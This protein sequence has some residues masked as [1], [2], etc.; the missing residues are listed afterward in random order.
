MTFADV[1]MADLVWLTSAITSI[2]Q[3]CHRVCM[4]KRKL[5]VWLP[6]SGTLFKAKNFRGVD[7]RSTCVS[8]GQSSLPWARHK[9]KVVINQKKIH[10]P[11]QLQDR[12]VSCGNVHIYRKASLSKNKQS[13][14]CLT[15]YADEY[16][17]F[18]P[19]TTF[20]RAPNRSNTL[21][22]ESIK[23]MIPVQL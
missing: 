9:R 12:T 15:R 10:W 3:L 21:F 11:R 5:I 8:S 14:L 17:I 6:G 22:T 13:T 23:Q 1:M 19:I 16:Y 4:N 20:K 2:L 7:S 18:R